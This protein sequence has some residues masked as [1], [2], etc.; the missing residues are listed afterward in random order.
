MLVLLALPSFGITTTASRLLGSERPAE[1]EELVERAP[2]C[3]QRRVHV[4][5]AVDRVAFIDCLSGA[6][7]QLTLASIQASPVVGHRLSN[8]LLAPLRC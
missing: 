2:C 6:K 1:A 7:I 3:S 4:S 8:G 5:R